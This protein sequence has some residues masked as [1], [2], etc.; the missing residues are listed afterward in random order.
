MMTQMTFVGRG[1]GLIDTGHVVGV[2]V[3]VVLSLFISSG[4]VMWACGQP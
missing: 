1:D 2:A 4:C 3:F